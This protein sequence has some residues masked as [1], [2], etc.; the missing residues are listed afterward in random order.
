MRKIMNVKNINN[1]DVVIAELEK[2]LIEFDKEMNKYHTDVYL[3]IDKD[4]NGT[5]DKFVNVVNN[6]WLDDDH[7][8]IYTDNPHYE[9]M[10]DLFPTVEEIA[11]CVNMDEIK[12]KT[13]EY[14]D[15]D[16]VDDVTYYNVMDYV[17]S[18]D[19]LMEMIYSTYCDCIDNIALDG[20]YYEKAKEIVN[21]FL[22]KIGE[23]ENEDL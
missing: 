15:I 7:I 3:Y 13:A 19:N 20:N 22:T 6:S 5:L 2:M 1:V 8:T 16:D 17:K 4:G 18:R 12:N 10:F 21:E 9:D 14:F 11:L 23:D